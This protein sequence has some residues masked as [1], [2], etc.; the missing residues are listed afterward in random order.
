M[1][2]HGEINR[3]AI[4]NGVYVRGVVS[5]LN[6]KRPNEKEEMLAMARQIL[7]GDLVQPIN[8]DGSINEDFKS[9]YH[10]HSVRLGIDQNHVPDFSDFK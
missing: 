7:H 9:L 3:G 4:I 1:Q 8:P 2:S 5:R 10:D 6:K